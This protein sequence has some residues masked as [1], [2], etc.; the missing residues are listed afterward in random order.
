MRKYIVNIT[1]KRMKTD[2]TIINDE[3][4]V[5]QMM[6]YGDCSKCLECENLHDPGI[7]H[8]R[9]DS[10]PCF[11]GKILVNPNEC[12]NFTRIQDDTDNR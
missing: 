1:G 3:H 5:K 6:K 7:N 4:L 11:L 12:P 10:P 2:H 8:D 9:N